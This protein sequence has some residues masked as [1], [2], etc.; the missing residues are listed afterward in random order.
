MYAI[1]RDCRLCT[2]A[3]HEWSATGLPWNQAEVRGLLQW[4]IKI[5][6]RLFP[7]VSLGQELP[8]PAPALATIETVTPQQA[9]EKAGRQM[10]LVRED[11]E[12]AG[13]RSMSG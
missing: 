9:V 6:L 7:P 13:A 10:G 1:M 4:L 11:E 3:F 5:T 12:K 2:R 8:L